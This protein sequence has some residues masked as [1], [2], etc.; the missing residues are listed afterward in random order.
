MRD[1]ALK[2]FL[3]Y[4]G[5]RLFF[6]VLTYFIAITIIF[7]L[8]RAIPGNPLAQILSRIATVGSANPEML[9]NVQKTL[10]EEFGLSKPLYA[11]YVDFITR[12][13]KGDFGTSIHYYPKKALDVIAPY[14]PWTLF[15]LIP[16]TLIAWIIGNTLG[17]V[18]GNKRGTW[19]DNIVLNSS[20][21]IS[22]IP[23]YWL[24]MLLIYVFAVNLG[25]F[26]NQGAYSQGIIPSFSL[27]F[28]LDVLYHYILPFLSIVIAAI[29]GWAIG[30]RLLVINELDADYTIFA[31]NLG[32]RDSTV[33]KYVFR[34]ILLPQITGLALNLGSALGGALITELI[35]NY[36]GTGYILFRSLSTLDYQLIQ[37]IFVIL[38]LAIYLANFIVDFIYAIVDP[39]IRL[40]QGEGS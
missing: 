23:Y 39:R 13:F 21:V 6:L 25:I 35:F 24:G 22:Q 17:A 28:I 12:L 20:L 14:I 10:M 11:Q 34:N 7:I 38:I 32:M 31:V 27:S 15:L 16:A 40:G 37:A 30:T 36:P 3:K 33:F 18:A 8:P 4:L 2:P 9:S 1:H 5:R 19:V 29:G 26:P